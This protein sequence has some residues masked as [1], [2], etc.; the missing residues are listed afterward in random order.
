MSIRT[1]RISEEIRK[2]I[3][4]RL[5]RGL[6]TPLPGFV[7]INKVDVSPDLKQAKVFFSVFGSDDECI[8]AIQVL[9]NEKR[10]I[11]QDVAQKVHLRVVPDLH[12]VL[13]ETPKK[14]AHIHALLNDLSKED[15][16]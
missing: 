5:I 14:A 16:S 9:R 3:S 11:R 2:V 13:D 12:F 7:T 10:F 8:A 6:K 1:E 15:N 4:E